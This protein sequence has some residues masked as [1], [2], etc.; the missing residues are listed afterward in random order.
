VVALIM[1]AGALIRHHLNRVDAGDDWRKF[2]WALPVAAFAV[3]AAIYVTAPS[4]PPAA[5][6][7][8]S[9]AQAIQIVQKHCVMCH[10][11]NPTHESFKEPPKNVAL[12]TTD[13]LRQ[14]AR[15]ILT[16]TVQNRAMPLGNQTA[17][18]EGERQELGAWVRALK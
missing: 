4:A 16:Q 8:V 6:A 10:A 14:Y 18:T 1:I 12:E 7:A 15:L 9:D 17:M 13:Q 5:G 11:K 3:I 2:D